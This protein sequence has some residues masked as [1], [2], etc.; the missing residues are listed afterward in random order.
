MLFFETD[1][2]HSKIA[3]AWL[4]TNM[5]PTLTGDITGKRDL[6]TA[7]EVSEFTINFTGVSQSSL[8]VRTFAQAILDRINITNANPNLRPAFVQAISADV[9]GVGRGYKQ[10]AE[11]LGSTAIRR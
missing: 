10:Q 8:G 3:K 1:P 11:E 6:T 2:T 5:Y 7:G 4:T 9:A